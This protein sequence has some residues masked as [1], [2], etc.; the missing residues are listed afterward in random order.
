MVIKQT[1]RLTQTEKLAVALLEDAAYKKNKLQN[2]AFLQNDI[3]FD[4]EIP[5]FFLGYVGERLVT[6]LAV[7]L[8]TRT[9]AELLAFTHPEFQNKGCFGLL[10]TEACRVLIA[11]RI[12][13]VVFAVE[14][15]SKSAHAVLKT[16]GNTKLLRSEYRMV[17][18]NLNR[19]PDPGGLQLFEVD[20]TNKELFR[21]ALAAAFPEAENQEN[22]YDSVL[23]SDLRRGYIV[24]RDRPVGVFNL[25]LGEEHTFLYGVGIAPDFRGKGYGKQLMGHAMR[26]GLTLGKRIVLDVDSQNPIAFHLYQSCGFQI[27]FQ[28]DYYGY[29]I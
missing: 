7:F 23:H 18:S 3:N 19:A 9:E 21:A 12:R 27:D 13:E 8:P 22:F 20:S 24:Y 1:N 26:Q 4:R 16:L 6:F 28:V 29:R 15:A 10:F 11:L 2:H 17:V 25:E 5:C 14:P